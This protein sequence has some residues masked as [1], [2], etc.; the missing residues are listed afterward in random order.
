MSKIKTLIT[1][2]I[3]EDMEYV[4]DFSTVGGS[5]Y[6]YSHFGNQ[7]DDF[8]EISDSVY[9]KTQLYQS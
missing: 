5:A 4:E 2:Y 6:L 9:L 3:G 1:A 8:S 7:Y